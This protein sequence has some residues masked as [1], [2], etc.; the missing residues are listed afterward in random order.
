MTDDLMQ[1]AR[2]AGFKTT[3]GQRPFVMASRLGCEIELERFAAL[4]EQRTIE[5]CA[6]VCE[7]QVAS[8][9]LVPLEMYRARFIADAI[10][11]LGAK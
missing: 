3:G 5:R 7:E 10:R 1:L 4:I 6:A 11:A 2:E 8:G 9:C